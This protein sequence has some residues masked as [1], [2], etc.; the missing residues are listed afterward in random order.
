MKS[1]KKNKAKAIQR[2]PQSREDAVWAVGRIGTLRREIAAQK[3]LSDEVIR[4]AGEKFETDTADLMA[5]LM[6]HEK[7]VQV[8]CEANRNTLT[9]DGKVK[10]HEFGTGII[11]WRSL[12]PSV[13]IKGVD[14]V[15]AACK[16]LGFD[17]FVRT[18]EEINKDAMLADP[19]KAV[20][21]SGVTISSDGEAFVI[22]PLEL[23]TLALKG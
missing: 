9:N 11:K 17:L 15:I 3:A 22:E 4:R 1:T 16:Q 10:F 20:L 18:K 6:E 8:W 13:K 14:A 2:V 23:E 21:I 19:A 7:G 5:E 12:A